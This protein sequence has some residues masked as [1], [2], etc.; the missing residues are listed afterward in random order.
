MMMHMMMQQMDAML[1]NWRVLNHDAMLI[2]M[3]SLVKLRASDS[4]SKSLTQSAP[5]VPCIV[6]LDYWRSILGYS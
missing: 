2:Q 4:T 1:A 3:I 6:N 5:A